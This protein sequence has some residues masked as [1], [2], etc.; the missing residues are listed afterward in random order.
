MEK[1]H[2][3]VPV[4][5]GVLDTTVSSKKMV[6]LWLKMKTTRRPQRLPLPPTATNRGSRRRRL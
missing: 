4:V 5:V 1:Q 6:P 2:Q 3:S